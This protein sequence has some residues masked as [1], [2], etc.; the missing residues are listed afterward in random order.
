MF[1]PVPTTTSLFQATMASKRLT[2]FPGSSQ[3]AEGFEEPVS[4]S[5]GSRGR[6]S[7]PHEQQTTAKPDKSKTPFINLP[8]TPFTSYNEPQV[9]L[10]EESPWRHY[11]HAYDLELGGTVAIASKIPATKSLFTIRSCSENSEK[12][13][14]LR[15]LKHSNLLTSYEVFLH[16]NL[17][18]IVSEKAEISLEELIVARPNE[19]QLA[20][21]I[22][23]VYMA[24]F[25]V[26]TEANFQSRY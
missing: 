21:I 16:K 13:S 3:W 6:A 2:V 1:F 5:H 25:L 10:I 24:C 9:P 15:Q 22:Y 11:L 7:D 20:A 8:V 4:P 18:Y 19:I 12:L 14:M 23:Q 17:F 26:N